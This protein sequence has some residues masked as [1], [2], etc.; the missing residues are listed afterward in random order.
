MIILK[1]SSCVFYWSGFNRLTYLSV[2]NS[3]LSKS[4]TQRP[5]KRRGVFSTL[6]QWEIWIFRTLYFMHRVQSNEEKQTARQIHEFCVNNW[7]QYT[8]TLLPAVAFRRVVQMFRSVPFYLSFFVWWSKGLARVLKCCS[9]FFFFSGRLPFIQ[10]L[11][12]KFQSSDVLRLSFS[13]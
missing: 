1:R 3:V 12:D 11:I 13:A 7:V 8:P 2:A 9:F 10:L 4:S 6:N 5:A